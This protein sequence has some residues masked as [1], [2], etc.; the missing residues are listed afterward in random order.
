M[1]N[2]KA[3][4]EYL[5]GAQEKN[6]LTLFGEPMYG[7]LDGDGD[8]D[9]ALL[10]ENEPGG[11]GTFYYAV[12]AIFGN[13]GTFTSTNALLLGDRIAPQT[14]ALK[15]GNV[16]YNYAVRKDSD[17]MSTPPSIGKT[18]WV[19][20][21]KSS[22]QIGELVKDFE[23][24]ADTSKMTLGMK[25]WEWIRTEKESGG[26]VIPKQKDVFTAS[27]D[28][29]GGVQ[30]KT[31]CNTITGKFKLRDGS[32]L[33]SDL[34]STRMYCEGSQEGEFSQSLSNVISYAFTSKGELLLTFGTTRGMMVFR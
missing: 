2:G 14:L 1:E 15:E 4:I 33:F 24:E 20:Y 17:P 6:M 11:S 12:F 19:H 9:A 7:D 29:H 18:L 27:F 23:G 28:V 13:N 25:K 32:L 26:T 34:A 30:F 5:P 22:N 16:A 21:D 8:I 10:L 31:D 3:I